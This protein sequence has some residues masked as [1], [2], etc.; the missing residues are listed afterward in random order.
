MNDRNFN[1]HVQ[2]Y[3]NFRTEQMWRETDRQIKLQN[4]AINLELA[5]YHLN[6]TVDYLI[7]NDWNQPRQVVY[8][9]RHLYFEPSWELFYVKIIAWN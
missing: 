8:E 3:D 9:T 1:S 6:N 4:Q 7:R 2:A 5:R